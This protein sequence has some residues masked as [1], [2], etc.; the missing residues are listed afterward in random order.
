MAQ[1][2][3]VVE[4]VWARFSTFLTEH[5]VHPELGF[6]PQ[7]VERAR[8]TTGFIQPTAYLVVGQADPVNFYRT[9]G[10][11][12]YDQ[13][14]SLDFAV[15]VAAADY[16]ALLRATDVVRAALIDFEPE[17]GGRI[18]AFGGSTARLPVDNFLTPYTYTQMLGFICSIGLEVSS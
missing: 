18:D 12:N 3:P 16:V 4:S 1:I 6:Q 15:L 8:D 10:D 14:Q 13:L 9:I 11:R 7:G 17:N 5:E 2:T